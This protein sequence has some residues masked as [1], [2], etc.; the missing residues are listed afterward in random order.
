MELTRRATVVATTMD[1]LAWLRKQLEEADA[2]LLREMVR[3]FAEALMGAEA[4]ALCGAGYGERSTER[5]NR[6]NGYRER[7]FDTRVGT[8]DLAV[9]K[10]RAGSYFPDWLV[11]PR[12][13]AERALVARTV[14][15]SEWLFFA[16]TAVWG[17]GGSSQPLATDLLRVVRPHKAVER[18]H[19]QEVERFRAAP[20]PLY[21]LPPAWTE[22]RHLGGWEGSWAKGQRPVTTALSLGHG[23]PLAEAG[24]Q[25]QVEVKA[26]RVE[27][28][29]GMTVRV[30]SRRQLAEDLWLQAAPAAHDPATHFGELAAVRRRPGPRSR[31]R[32]M[33]GWSPTSRVSAA[34][35]RPGPATT[36]SSI[37]RTLPREWR[38]RTRL[39][40]RS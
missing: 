1:L 7:R 25:L 26:E 11:Q 27:P 23:D 17:A 4:D 19:E 32:W 37:S 2:D 39:L 8:I 21:S 13:R 34:S 31:S 28:E 16:S 40:I 14:F 30:G 18:D 35:R 38:W 10:L 20:F 15:A 22:P 3:C 29:L 6:R 5:A 12:R 33:A 9:P 24:P 36:T